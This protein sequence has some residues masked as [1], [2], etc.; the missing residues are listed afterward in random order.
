M[1]VGVE[2]SYSS[3][4]LPSVPLTNVQD[5]ALDAV[6]AILTAPWPIT[7][8]SLFFKPALSNTSRVPTFSG[9]KIS[10]PELCL[11]RAMLHTDTTLMFAIVFKLRQIKALSSIMV[12]T[13][14]IV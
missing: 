5:G 10:S 1:S 13:F 4:D 3:H 12:R 9:L 14:Y 11:A 7:L 8:F 6:F 2:N